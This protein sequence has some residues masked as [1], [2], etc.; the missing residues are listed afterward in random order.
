MSK[1]P[2]VLLVDDD[3]RVLD[4]LQ[5][6]LRSQFEPVAAISVEDAHV[7]LQTQEPFAVVVS[8]LRMPKT[9]GVAFLSSVRE[10]APDSVRILLT[11]FGDLEVAA[12]AVNDGQVFR[13]LRKPCPTT[14]F[15]A[16]IKA[17]VDQHKLLVAQ[18]ELLEGTLHG[19]VDA[20]ADVL[21]IASPLAF[22]RAQRVRECVGAY[23]ERFN[24]GHRWQL[25]VA[26]TLS[27]I[28]AA[29][30]PPDLIKKVYFAHPLTDAEQ[31]RV[32][33]LPSHAVAVVA[34][35]PRLEAVREILAHLSAATLPP[36][37]PGHD[38]FVRLGVALLRIAF[39]FDVCITRGHSVQ[40]AIAEMVNRVGVYDPDV[41]ESFS[42]WQGELGRTMRTR[43]V[44][45]AELA[46]G[47]TLA[48]DVVD[49]HGVLLV[50][51]GQRVSPRALDL[52]RSYFGPDC[53]ARKVQIRMDMVN[54]EAVPPDN[55]LHVA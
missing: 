43:E 28:G 22:A 33:K 9:N 46:V 8:D 55:A 39:D 15:I 27:Q 54:D 3:Q 34:H 5:R 13:F 20:L 4:A 14:T 17:A 32:A 21:A 7:A 11:G 26:A 23:V 53:I 40:S 24:V 2:R 47:M 29:S 1:L 12:K 42:A 18:H 50:A 37:A 19:C 31:S 36:R 52:I 41:L 25:E 38:E 16:A 48:D 45:L 51:R 35:V 10:L 49:D 44:F 30:L 6:I